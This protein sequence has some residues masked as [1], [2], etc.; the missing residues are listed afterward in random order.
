MA[1][2]KSGCLKIII[3]GIKKYKKTLIKLRNELL[4]K[5]LIVKISAIN[6]IKKTLKNSEPWKLK[7]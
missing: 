2:P 6:N 5:F 4:N 3:N 7:K 1:F